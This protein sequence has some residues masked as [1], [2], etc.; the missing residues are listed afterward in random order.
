MTQFLYFSLY[1]NAVV[2]IFAGVVHFVKPKIYIHI[3]PPF[4]PAKATLNYLSGLAEIVLG[5]GLLWQPT[6]IWASYGLILLLTSFFLVHVGHLFYEPS[7]LSKIKYKKLL[8]WGRFLF[9]FVL[10][11]W[12]Y[13]I[14][15]L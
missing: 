9:Q 3:M 10:I 6:R 4:F 7:V 11:W 14:G 15:K 12:V 5:V 1:F 2:Y 13:A 8:L